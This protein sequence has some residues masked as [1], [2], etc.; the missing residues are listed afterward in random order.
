MEPTLKNIAKLLGLFLL[1]ISIYLSYDGFDQGVTG[2]NTTYS[3]LAKV[4]GLV[5]AV[6]VGVLQFVFSSR[7]EQLNTT[8][9]GA[10]L[11]SYAYSIYTNYLG[12]KHLLGM[13]DMTA[14]A[15]AFFMDIVPEPMIAW[16]L[17]DSMKG[18]V[19]G[20]LG[21]WF[22]GY[23]PKPQQQPSKQEQDTR[24]RPEYRPMDANVMERLSKAQGIHQMQE[25]REGQGKQNQGKQ[26]QNNRHYGR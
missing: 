25:R 23:Q 15:T 8:L 12:A 13:D 2:G 22:T 7:Y 10:G 24:P 5:I 6:S 20:N 16:G 4:I 14:I 17:G 11:V 26:Q 3:N 19:L 21:K 1:A 9:K 18:D